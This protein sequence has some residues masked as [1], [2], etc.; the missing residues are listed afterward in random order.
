[1]EKSSDSWQINS[2]KGTSVSSADAQRRLHRA[3]RS[4]IKREAPSFQLL[5]GPI[6]IMRIRCR[7]SDQ[8]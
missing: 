1:M 5:V 8:E 2:H 7:L 3:S 6:Y 4:L